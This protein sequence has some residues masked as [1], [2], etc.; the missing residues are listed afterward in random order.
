[1]TQISQAAGPQVVAGSSQVSVDDALDQIGLGPFQWK[2]LA[3]CGLTWAAD[4][5]EVLLMSFAL[6]G[7]RA[8]F[9]LEG[10]S[11]VPLLTA[12]FLGMFVGAIFWGNLADRIGRRNVFLITVSLGVIFGLSGALAPTVTLLMVARFLTGFAIG[13]TLPVDYAMMAEFVPTAWRGKFLVYLESFWAVGTIIVAGLAWYLNSVMAPEDAWRWLLGLAALPMLIGL[14]AR[15]GIPDSPR[16]LLGRGQD[17]RARAAVDTVARSNGN[18]DALAGIQLAPPLQQARVSAASLFSGSLSKRTILLALV[19]FG[20]SLGYYGIFTWLPTYLRAGGM[21]LADVYRT[22]LL[23]AF[24]QLPGYFLAA[25]LVDAVGRRA[26]VAGFLAVGAVSTYLF[27]SASGAGSVLAT[28]ALLSAA[29]LGA[30]GSVYAYT[31]ELFPTSVRSTAMGLMSA[32]ARVAGLIAPSL[33]AMLVTGNLSAALSVFAASFA[34]A[35]I[36]A[37]SIGTETRGKQLEEVTA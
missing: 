33:G 32:A 24:A 18:A 7:I 1:M 23:L 3:I 11:A 28:S 4:A 9:G 16:F 30:W 22:T 15:F 26:T 6:P 12:T 21:E 8:E 36:A 10:A 20:L 31:P 25:Y 35:A 2:L 5:M 27:L 37:W 19:W 13:G 17:A 14:L 34:V 29:L